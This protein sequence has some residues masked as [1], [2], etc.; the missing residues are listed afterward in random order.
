[1]TRFLL[2]VGIGFALLAGCETGCRNDCEDAYDQCIEDSGDE[3]ECSATRERCEA[4]C[5]PDPQL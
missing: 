2:L 1:M 3:Q 4:E 5:T